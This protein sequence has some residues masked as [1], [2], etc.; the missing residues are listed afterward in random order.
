MDHLGIR[1]FMVLGRDGRFSPFRLR[2]GRAREKPLDLDRRGDH[3][4]ID[5]VPFRSQCRREVPQEVTCGEVQ[6]PVKR[7]R[8]QV[9]VCDRVLETGLGLVLVL[10]SGRLIE[11]SELKRP[12]SRWRIGIRRGS[13]GQGTFIHR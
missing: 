8:D 1:E 10:C 9:K 7:H 4:C 6:R 5:R 12:L 3:D 13:A 2:Q 11:S